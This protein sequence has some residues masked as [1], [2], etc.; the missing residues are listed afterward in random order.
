MSC[1]C[2]TWIWFKL[3]IFF[4]LY[5]LPAVIIAQPHRSSIWNVDILT[6]P[7]PPPDKGPPLSAGALRDK[8][9]LKYEIIGIVGSYLAW[10]SLTV[11]LLVLVGN[12]LRRRTQTSNR[13]LSMEIIRPSHPLLDRTPMSAS[14][15][16]TDLGPLPSPLKSP[17][18]GKMASLRSWAKGGPGPTTA[19]SRNPSNMSAGVASTVDERILEADKA[20]NMDDLTKLY[21]AVMAHDDEQQSRKASM[22]TA[23]N[24]S[25]RTSPRSPQFS[26][27]HQAHAPL[28][29]PVSTYCYP[30]S[31]PRSPPYTPRVHHG[32]PMLP[33]TPNYT[34]QYHQHQ[35]QQPQ[36]P[37]AYSA[38]TIDSPATSPLFHPLAPTPI[39]EQDEEDNQDS[40]VPSRA[41]SS[42]RKPGR[43]SSALALLPGRS[44]PSDQLA[45][46]TATGIDNNTK[47]KKRPSAI[48]VRG[49]PIS[50]PLPSTESQG[51]NYFIAMGSSHST[52]VYDNPGRPP[53]PP[54]QK[55]ATVSTTAAQEMGK[56]PAA[57]STV[58]NGGVDGT[59]DRDPA[60]ASS[61]RTEE[62]NP[63][64]YSLPFRQFY[65]NGSLKSAPPTKTTFVDRRESMLGTH[66]KTGVP[67]T[68]YSPYM[69]YTPMTPVTPR[70]LVTKKEMKKN[71]KKEGLKV[72]SEDDMVMSDEDMWG[73]MK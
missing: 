58:R 48:S 11:V 21:A 38:H 17:R 56:G 36:S 43:I 23:S 26:V 9:K 45:Y 63:T 35:L 42:S 8:S 29:S 25:A 68:P 6:N 65:S 32:G 12:R 47:S 10:L 20:R 14:T 22:T 62:A 1:R 13:S 16:A 28:A 53:V 61:V 18:S 57:N 2:S 44:S 24:Y 55:S 51:S 50:Q 69:P 19:H 40:F 67:Q 5:G 73:E 64:S 49:Q 59:P 33:Q 70:T 71:R 41:N 7:A 3:F 27:S 4:V 31:T 15:A 54:S 72:L 46:K 37:A 30:P 34:Q 60:A 52:R 39:V 66:P